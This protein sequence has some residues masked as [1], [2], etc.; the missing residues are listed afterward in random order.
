[1]GEAAAVLHVHSQSRSQRRIT[2]AL[3]IVRKNVHRHA[4][5]YASGGASGLV[6]MGPPRPPARRLKN[7]ART[8]ARAL[9]GGSATRACR[10]AGS[11]TAAAPER[12]RPPHAGRG[13]WRLRPCLCSAAPASPAVRAHFNGRRGRGVAAGEAYRP[14]PGRARRTTASRPGRWCGRGG[15]GCSGAAVDYRRLSLLR[16]LRCGRSIASV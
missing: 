11:A 3:G 15:V 13:R 6:Q 2:E 8:V 12:T 14:L 10:R 5:R 16:Q 9:A 1:M 7:S 4:R